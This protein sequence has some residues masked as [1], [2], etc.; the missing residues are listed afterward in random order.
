[1]APNTTPCTRPEAGLVVSAGGGRPS[2]CAKSCILVASALI[3]GPQRTCI[4]EQT[5]K[6]WGPIHC[7]SPNLKVGGPVSPGPHSCCTYVLLM[8][9]ICITHIEIHALHTYVEVCLYIFIFM[10][11]YSINGSHLTWQCSRSRVFLLE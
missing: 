1:M 3:S 11:I 9:V 6:C 10:T 8:F 5:T 7:W 2:R 4:S